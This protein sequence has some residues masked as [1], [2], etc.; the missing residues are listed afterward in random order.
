MRPGGGSLVARRCGE[1]GY[2]RGGYKKKRPIKKECGYKNKSAPRG[3]RAV[4]RGAQCYLS[5]GRCFA[6]SSPSA[7]SR[8]RYSLYCCSVS[9]GIFFFLRAIKNDLRAFFVIMRGGRGFYS[10]IA[11]YAV[12]R[13]AR[14]ARLRRPLSRLSSFPQRRRLSPVWSRR[15]RRGW[16]LPCARC[17][18][19]ARRWRK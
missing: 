18:C 15:I 14:A 7:L 16:S 1:S 19:P 6:P 10:V 11:Y 17:L 8:A 12:I 4:P 13:R 3:H 9:F 2:K 5:S